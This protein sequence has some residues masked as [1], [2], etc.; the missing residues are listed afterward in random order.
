MVT[1]ITFIPRMYGGPGEPVKL[2]V[3]NFNL[4]NNE[5]KRIKTLGLTIILVIIFFGCEEL[6]DPAGQ[7]NIGVVPLI[8]DV[9]G[10]FISGESG[11]NIQFTVDLASGSTVDNAEIEVSRQDNFERVKISDL[12]TFPST[13]TFTLGQIAEKLGV[14]NAGDLIYIEVVTTK[15]GI[16]TRSN[17]ALALIVYCEYD[18]LL[19]VGSYHS[20]SPPNE[21]NSEGDIAIKADPN[22]P[23]TVYVTG[24]EALE[25]LNEDQG[26]LVMHIDP[27][28]FAV[29][30]DKT[31]LASD[32]WGDTNIAYEGTGNY[33]SCSGSYSMSF[34]IS[35]DQSDYGVYAFTFT[36]N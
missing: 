8:S 23:Y 11:S 15:N 5:M 28:T 26:P 9:A 3:S 19:A 14:I 36:R 29:T 21:W 30:A 25:G 13:F 34:D 2:S 10:I 27:V 12:T 18:P 32:A 33:N 6:K 24:L 22:D 17:A 16:S 20:V 31:V 35:T 1:A 4:K 7:R